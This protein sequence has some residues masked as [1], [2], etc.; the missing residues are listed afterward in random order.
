MPKPHWI[1]LSF[2]SMAL[3]LAMSCAP[4]EEP[5]VDDCADEV[6]GEWESVEEFGCPLVDPN[7]T[8]RHMLSLDGANYVWSPD[9]VFEGPYT[10]SDGLLDGRSESGAEVFTAN[11]DVEADTLE[12]IWDDQ[13]APVPYRRVP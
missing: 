5:Q 6:S 8:Y 4:E 11:Y 7:C 3:V 9:E 13:T 10:C 1:W 2:S 12:L